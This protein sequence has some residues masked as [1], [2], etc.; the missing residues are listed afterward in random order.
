MRLGFQFSPTTG[1]APARAAAATKTYSASLRMVYAF[2]PHLM[3]KDHAAI[4][5]VSSGLARSARTNTATAT[6]RR[7]QT[8]QIRR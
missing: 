4:I 5:N 7:R 2:L 3:A 1:S 8:Y 6:W